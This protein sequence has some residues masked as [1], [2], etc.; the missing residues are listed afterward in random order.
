[1]PALRAKASA[2]FNHSTKLATARAA[3]EAPIHRGLSVAELFHSAGDSQ[4]IVAEFQSHRELI[5]KFQQ[6]LPP[7]PNLGKKPSNE[8]AQLITIHTIAFGAMI[9]LHSLRA[10][11]DIT[12]ANSCA[13]G[14]ESITKLLENVDA[15]NADMLDPIVGVSVL[16]IADPGLLH[17][18]YHSL[19]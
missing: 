2:L 7:A 15:Q 8:A 5:A 4:D 10:S 19:R 18:D 17:S 16:I 9:E 3:G 14:A 13:R 1:L 6:S 12:A 11:V